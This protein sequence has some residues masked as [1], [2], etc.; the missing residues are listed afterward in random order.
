MHVRWYGQSAFLLSDGQRRLMIDPFGDGKALAGRGLRFG[1]PPIE[2][3]DADLLLITHEHSDHNNAVAVTG[4]PQVIRAAGRFDTPLGEV[5]GIAAEHDDA[6][7]TE[8]GANTIYRFVVDGL[9][10]CHLGDL[11]QRELRA[12]QREAIGSPDVLFVPV[13]GGP[14]IGASE[15]ATLVRELGPRIVVPMHYRTDA[16]DFL[17][18]VEPFVDDLDEDVDVV[19]LDEPEFD[20]AALPGGGAAT[21]LV[22]PRAPLDA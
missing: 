21:S 12:P 3:V 9:Q 4:E 11:G 2:R 6:A 5:V 14:T 7:G 17:E 19:W 22:I 1:Y 13:G 15:A 20:A 18:P 8:R 10:A 16:L